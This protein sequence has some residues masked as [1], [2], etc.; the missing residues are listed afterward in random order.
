MQRRTLLAGTAALAATVPL[1]RVAA[2]A[3]GT[4]TK[5]TW[6]HAMTGALG[7]QV[8]RIVTT[9]NASQSEV[10]VEAIQ[11]GT[12]PEVM[13]ETIAAW[14]AN[15]APHIAQVFDVGTGSM[16]QAGPATKQVWQL[17]EETGV[18]LDPDAYIASVRGYYSLA[19]G[20]LA[21]MPFNSST[22]VMWYNKDAFSAAGLDPEKPPETWDALRVA[23]REIK[24]KLDAD[25]GKPADQRAM[26]GVTMPMTSAWFTWVQYEQYAAIHNIPFATEDNGF[27]GLGAVLKLDSPP[28][29]KQTARFLEMAKEGTF[30]YT[31]RDSTPS[32]V[33][34]SGQA[35][36]C[37]DSSAG[38]G[39]ILRSAKF[40]WGEA[41][42][43]YDPSV[44]AKPIN[45]IIGGAALWAMTA[46]GRTAAEYK[47][48]ATFMK[49]IGTPEQ[50]MLW[51]KN[52]GYI[53]VTM[54]G[55]E[56]TRKQG[57]YRKPEGAGADVPIKQLNRGEVTP[58]SR[59]VRLGNLPEI[60][61]IIYEELEKAL[62]GQQDAKQALNNATERGNKV[63]RDFQKSA[64]G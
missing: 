41:L 46:K 3:Q 58:L 4:K 37:F 53:P 28:M 12:Y 5:I 45:S 6:W 24:A 17:I 9:F 34:Y 27:N 48:V 52:T 62:Q 38:R 39:N 31:G 50:D 11:K 43:P 56:L 18:A 61:V 25:A 35:A 33:F 7:D 1:L 30:K 16:L 36:V 64:N 54:A 19:N 21:A 44:I 29:I 14:R 8:E 40:K 57:Y 23:L 32:A 2:Q 26:G 63:L 20:K 15:K 51:G 47:A 55:Y 60:R 49:F 22:A 42:L 13:T 10:E 59:G